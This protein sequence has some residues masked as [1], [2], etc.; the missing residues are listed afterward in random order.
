MLGFPVQVFIVVGLI[1]LVYQYWVHTEM[2]GKLGWV[3]RVFVTPSNHRVHHGQND[4][5]IDKNYGGIF[6]LWDRL[7]GTFAAERDHEQIFYGVRKPLASYNAVWGNCNV[8]RDLWR[9]SR[10]AWQQQGASAA[11]AVWFGPPAGWGGTLEHL[12]TATLH[13][14]DRATPASVR[15]YAFIQYAITVVCATH[16]IAIAPQ[17]NWAVRAA[18][19]LIITAGALS[20]GWLLEGRARARAIEAGRLVVVGGLFLAL[21]LWF[22]WQAPPQVKLAVTALLLT[23][24]AWVAASGDRQPAR[25]A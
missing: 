7:F 5:C 23:S 1:D 14:F 13:R 16:F 9:A 25:D 21:P 19:A 12:D 3:D 18:Y 4:Y 22:G 2:V 8:W 24:L 17:L 6:I 10:A 20:T 11:V 15:R